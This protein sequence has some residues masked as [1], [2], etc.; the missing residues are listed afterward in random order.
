MMLTSWSC[1]TGFEFLDALS[2]RALL[3]PELRSP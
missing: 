2:E 3:E 1:T